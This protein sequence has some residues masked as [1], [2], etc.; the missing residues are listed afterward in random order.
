[1]KYA[2]VI[3]DGAADVPINELGGRT[4]LEAAN[5]PNMDWIAANG[6]CGTV[7]N[8][9]PEMPCGSDVAILSVLG[10]DPR[11][12]YT[13]RAPLEAAARGLEIK[14]HEWV[15]RCNLVTVV[16][17][18][19]EDHSSGNISTE[20]G[21]ALISELN[22]ILANEQMHFYSGVS[23]RHLMTLSGKSDVTTTPPHDILGQTIAPHLPKGRGS[24]LLVTLIDRS[25]AILA[26]AEINHIRRDLG[27]NP[28][29]HIWLWG[30]GQMPKLPTFA[31][32]FGIA[33]AASISAVD[34]V[35][36]M[37]KLIGWDHIEVAGATGFVDTNY[38]G[39]GAAA[40]E[41]LVDHD[42]VFVHVEA[43]DEAGHQADAANKVHAIEQIDRHVVGTLL[44]Y[45]R[46]NQTDDWRIM[47]LPDHPT[48]CSLR[49]HTGEPVPFALAGKRI[50]SVI[51]RPFTE[52]A[53]AAA[54]LHIAHGCELMEFFLKVR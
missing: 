39:K 47:V 41:A 11:E 1:M 18:V 10:Y 54:D 35:R 52:S 48:P 50:E 7:R 31:D 22:R 46:D 5:I 53:A 9:P 28:A 8:V 25:E 42:L 3:P 38:A 44:E 34:L 2:I 49:T 27:E 32:R 16:D 14:P 13:G 4:P 29:T 17:G 45:L 37:S 15:F 26:E 51:Q 30:Q 43:P 19:M 36:G 21:A 20:E 6:K 24:D 40:V 23:Y 33:S 12:Y